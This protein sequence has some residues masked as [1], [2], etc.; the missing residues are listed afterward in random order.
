MLFGGC[1]NKKSCYLFS[2]SS[3]QWTRLPDLLTERSYHQS[4]KINKSIFLIGG[5]NNKTIE[6][7]EVSSKSL[8][9]I[10]TSRMSGRCLF[11][12]CLYYNEMLLIAGGEDDDEIV[13]NNCVLFNTSYKKFMLFKY[14]QFKHLQSMNIKKW[15]HVLV[16]MSSIIYSIGGCNDKDKYLSSIE[17]FNPS[18]EEW[19]ISTFELQIARCDHQA[20]AHKHFIYVFGGISN[21]GR[22]ATIEKI[23]TVTKCV[24]IIPTQIRVTRSSF[25]VAKVNEKVHLLGGETGTFTNTDSVEIFDLN[26]EQIEQGVK[27]P[28]END[29]F[30]ACVL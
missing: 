2:T 5:E 3:Q 27:M 4:T 18:T 7:Y 15:G 13:T 30:T 17:E 14:N 25:A 19:R 29:G 16:N 21:D 8:K 1:D 10:A 24:E 23:D 26:T 20:V 6:E 12:M 28:F 22:T 11:G 9:L